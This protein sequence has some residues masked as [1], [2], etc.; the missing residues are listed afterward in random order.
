MRK[1]ALRHAVHSGRELP[2]RCYW[3]YFHCRRVATGPLCRVSSVL[4][5]IS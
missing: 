4:Q 2:Q 1:E 5:L 3:D